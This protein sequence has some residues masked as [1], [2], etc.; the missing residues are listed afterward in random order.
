MSINYIMGKISM[1]IYLLCCNTCAEIE[2][3]KSRHK[4]NYIIATSKYDLYIELKKKESKVIFLESSQTIPYEKTWE[5]LEKIHSGI[6]SGKAYK[7]FR[8]F[9]FSYNIEGGF[10]F[11]ISQMIINL[12]LIHKIVLDYQI[13]GIYLFDNKDNWVINESIF[14]Y[15]KSINLPCHIL[16]A[17]GETKVCLKTLETMNMNSVDIVDSLLLKEKKV[18]D[19]IKL[20]SSK[21]FDTKV[22]EEEVGALYCCVQSYPKHME[23]MKRRIDAIGRYVK[24]ICYYDTEDVKKFNDIGMDAECIEDYFILEDFFLEYE[25]IKKERTWILQ[26]LESNLHVLYLNVDLTAYLCMKVRNYYYRELVKQLYISVCAQNYFKY[27]NFKYIHMWGDTNFWE[28]WL[29]YDYTRKRN[30]KLFLIDW[31]S[32]IR[33]KMKQLY[34]YMISKAF[35]PKI[36]YDQYKDMYHGQLFLIDDVVWVK[37]SPS[38]TCYDTIKE[39]KTVA[40]LPTGIV[41]GF[42]TYYFYYN[43]MNKVINILLS[44][45]YKI[46]LKNHPGCTD[47]WE[48]DVKHIFGKNLNIKFLNSFDMVEDVLKECYMIITDISSAAFDAALAQKAVFCIVDEQG[49]SYI[50]QHQQGFCIYQNISE[51]INEMETA[52]N[53]DK[54]YKAIIER[55]N[56]YMSNLGC[57]SCK[58]GLIQEFLE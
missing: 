44:K 45:D 18:I 14:L 27:H 53:D 25:R 22:V 29:C 32:F 41:G 33:I 23:W 19:S 49:D 35:V 40:I 24:I 30:T 10:P 56:A 12:E 16:D 5:I 1:D 6:K 4:S 13:K 39:K 37:K 47:D 3:L 58:R 57:G 48:K 2:I 26:M 17:D 36:L 55:Q 11:K 15:A 28:T 43:I 42:S 34:P 9:H 51:M 46:I 50:S 31:S 8:L 52:I 7:Y 20:K 21:M 38:V 54:K